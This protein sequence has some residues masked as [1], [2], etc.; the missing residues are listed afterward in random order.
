MSKNNNIVID[1]D[2]VGSIEQHDVRPIPAEDRHGKPK[3]LFLMWVGA[4]TN[5][6][7]LL[8]G[9]LLVTLGLS[10]SEAIFAVLVGNL[11]GCSVLGLSSIMGP[12]TGS[13]GIMTSRPAFGQFGSYLPVIISTL[14]VLGWFSI[15]SVVATE[16]LQELF[17]IAGLP[18]NQ[19]MM[20]IALGLVLI[21]EIL[22]AIY[23]H[24]TIIAAEK[25]ISIVLGVLFLGLLLFILPQ[26]DW[27][28]PN[29]VVEGDGVTKIG[30]WILAMG[31]IFSYPISWANF[32]SDY[33]RYFKKDTNWKE[34]AFYAGSGQFIAL[35][36]CEIIGVLF[37]AA[38][39]GTLTDP[40]QQLPGLLPTWYLVPFLLAVIIGCIATNVPNGYTAGLGLLALRIPISRVKSILVIGAFTLVF[41]IATLIFGQFFTV[42]QQWLSYI[43]IWTCPWIAVVIV[44]FFMRK[45]NYLEKDLMLWGEGEYWY[46]TGIFW[47]GVAAFLIG[48]VL[49]IAFANSAMFVS[50]ISTMYLGGADLSFEVGLISSGLLYYFFAR[51][52]STFARAKTM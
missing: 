45:G 10:I 36:L 1:A 27:S 52:Q 39:G 40:V 11:L 22:L 29:M 8:T 47:S 26:V 21:G 37:A 49:S 31:I 28:F 30:M 34:V 48:L 6:V 51:G 16:G 35:T 46:K 20:W 41:R 33:S 17:K 7:V 2:K 23:G 50:P 14:S 18:D 25:Y 24:A 42:Y 38:L 43:I 9:A 3:D 13:A 12:R 19:L 32:A 15:N 4:N 5:Y 44:D